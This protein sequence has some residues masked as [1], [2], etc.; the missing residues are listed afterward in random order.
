MARNNSPKIEPIVTLNGKAAE[1]ALDALKTKAKALRDA[2]IEASKAG[3]DTKVRQIDKELKSIENT[4]RSIRKQTFDYN[5]V[6]KNLNSST[7]KDLE[8]SSKALKNEI[9][10]LTPETEAFIQKTKQLE[11]VTSRLDQLN[12]RYRETHS[13]L[14]RTGDKFNKYFGLVTAGIA[15]IT[16]MSMALRGASEKAAQMDDVYSDVMK[17]T[18]LTRAEVVLLNDEFKKLD[19]RTSRE[20]LNQLARDAGKL[21]IEGSQNILEFVT[22]ANKINVA[23]KEDLGEGAIIDI[24]KLAEVFKFT[25][26]LGVE[27]SYLAIGSAINAIGQASS[28]SEAYLVEFA[29]RSAGAAYQA[30]LSFQDTIGY[31]SALDQSG[32]NVELAATAFQTFI[33][34]MFTETSKFAKLTGTDLLSF[35]KLLSED[36]NSAILLVLNSIKDSGGFDRMAPIFKELGTDGARA[37]S[38]LASMS[39]NIDLITEAQKLSNVEFAKAN[40]IENEYNTKNNN[41]QAQLEK[42]RKAFQDQVIILGER[43]SPVMLQTTNVTTW[44]V[45]AVSLL[46]KE[47]V[48]SALIF[49]GAIVAYKSWA[50]IVAFGN[51]VMAAGRITY[52]LFASAISLLSG[53][54]TRAAAAWKLLNVSFSSTAVGA[55]I[56]AITMLGVGLY[57]LITYQSELTKA[58]KQYYKETEM[59]KKEANEYL[60]ILENSVKGSDEYKEALNKLTEKYGPYIAHLINEQGYLE[61]IDRARRSINEAIEDSIARKIKEQTITDAISKSLDKQADSYEA[62]VETLMKNSGLSEDLSRR[63]ATSFAESVK[64][65]QNWE[66]LVNNLFKKVKSH[67]HISPF[68]QFANEYTSMM[69]EIETINKRFY[70]LNNRDVDII[71]PPRPSKNPNPTKPATDNNDSVKLTEEELKK[72]AEAK[73]KAFKKELELLEQKNAKEASLRKASFSAGFYDQEAYEAVMVALSLN[74]MLEKINLYRKYGKD[75]SEIEDSIFTVVADSQKKA[76]KAT[77]DALNRLT[78][79]YKDLDNKTTKQQKEDIDPAEEYEINKYKKRLDYLKDYSSKIRNEDLSDAKSKRD[80]E[81]KDLKDSLNAK[82]LTEKEYQ[83]KKRQI[84]LEYANKIASEVNGVVQA[85]AD[86]FFAI[87]DAEFDKLDREKEKELALYGDSAD[88]RAEIENKYEKKKFDLQQKYADMEM[89]VKISQAIASGAV[90]A[91]TAWSQLGIFGGPA[92]ALIAATT[93][94]NVATII[95]QRNAIKSMTFSGSSGASKKRTVNPGYSSGGFTDKDPDDNTPVGVVHANEWVAPAAMVRANPLLF[96]NL[97]RQRAAKSYVSTPKGFSTG[98]FTSPQNVGST[99]PALY[100]ELVLL[101]RYFKENPLKSYVVLSDIDKQRDLKDRIKETGSL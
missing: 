96:L 21:G 13:W 98:G 64:E 86:L 58:I 95:A 57:K 2:M 5:N 83:Q 67:F 84:N 27:K 79:L 93:L 46:N 42:A 11:Q 76:I 59:A 94:M 80:K 10:Q 24:G 99:D 92:A 52:L 6:L 63:Y 31:A 22:A 74:T 85:A 34:K 70:Q 30:K 4:Q 101:L 26:T 66:T 39:S 36:V 73:E 15:S 41:K 60:E 89:A 82:L 43:L 28:A 54:T 16:G 12:G 35:K 53:N 44:F 1:N 9:R 14:S 7:I 77:E 68:R 23:L 32:H 71:G 65:G 51:G 49:A 88:K 33:M 91:M 87:K 45:K 50:T 72:I 19:T 25:E 17:T 97:E 37:V 20:E 8:K 62:I 78:Q 100:R 55:I 38:V 61:N 69:A 40:S 56:T 48:L 90:A 81:L 47:I 18:G 29:K 75:V 3:D